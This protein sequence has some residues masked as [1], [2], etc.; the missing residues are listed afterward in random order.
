MMETAALLS[1]LAIAGVSWMSY[2]LCITAQVRVA[3]MAEQRYPGREAQVSAVLYDVGHA[4]LAPLLH[5]YCSDAAVRLLSKALDLSIP[6]CVACCLVGLNF[7]TIDQRPVRIVSVTLLI[8][9]LFLFRCATFCLTVLPQCDFRPKQYDPRADSPWK[10]ALQIFTLQRYEFGYKNDLMFSGHVSILLI[11]ALFIN[12]YTCLPPLLK[13]LQF[14]AIPWVS[15]SL[16]ALKR[17][18]SIDVVFA[19]LATWVFWRLFQDGV[20][21]MM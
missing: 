19:W 11:C 14:V 21:W 7:F 4:Y 17:H 6:L 1:L 8:A 18:Y 3:A 12:Y 13:T 5:R 15:L 10:W 9:A 2:A 16:V 20:D